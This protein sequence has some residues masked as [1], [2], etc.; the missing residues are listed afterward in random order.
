MTLISPAS[1]TDRFVHNQHAST[2]DIKTSQL[3][4]VTYHDGER[5]RLR[6]AATALT[7]GRL[8]DRHLLHVLHQPPGV[9]WAQIQQAALEDYR[10]A[11]TTRSPRCGPG[12]VGGPNS[13]HLGDDHDREHLLVCD[14]CG[15]AYPRP[16]PTGPDWRAG[17]QCPHRDTSTPL[18][19][20]QR[21]Q[22]PT[23]D[24]RLTAICDRL[25]AGRKAALPPPG[26]PGH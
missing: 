16:D 4:D 13:T 25:I 22:V 18:P 23:L 17:E 2:V 8:V 21:D 6:P 5:P 14:T 20:E 10:A 19:Y 11:A 7:A 12:W 15:I 1:R 3:L 26:Q 9:T 24:D